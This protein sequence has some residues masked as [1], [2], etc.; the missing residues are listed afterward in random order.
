MPLYNF[1]KFEKLGTYEDLSI[2]Q[3]L[4]SV[5]IWIEEKIQKLT[6][7]LVYSLMMHFEAVM[8]GMGLIGYISYTNYCWIGA[9]SAVV[10]S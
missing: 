2:L 5:L 9:F 10:S 1:T 7:G 3:R 8:I 6:H 4:R